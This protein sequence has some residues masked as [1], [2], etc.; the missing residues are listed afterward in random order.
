[1]P[2]I[3]AQ[4]EKAQQ[5]YALVSNLQ[6]RLVM[7]LNQLSSSMGEDKAFEELTWLRDEGLH[8]GGNRFEFRDEKLF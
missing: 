1:M 4:S 3:L 2:L 7:K 5:A 6:S 8:G